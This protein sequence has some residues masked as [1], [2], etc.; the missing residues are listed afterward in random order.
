MLGR[1]EFLLPVA[2]GDLHDGAEPLDGLRCHARRHEAHL[3]RPAEA[4]ELAVMRLDQVAADVDRER[5]QRG[6][7]NAGSE[8]VSV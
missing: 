2:L 7:G 4:P 5:F 6:G 8:S 1:D 3:F